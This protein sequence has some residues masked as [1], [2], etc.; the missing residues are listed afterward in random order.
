[1]RSCRIW[2]VLVFPVVVV[3]FIVG[4]PFRVVIGIRVRVRIVI[5][6]RIRVGIGIGIRIRI[7]VF[8]G[9]FL[10]GVDYHLIL[11]WLCLY[12]LLLFLSVLALEF[13]VSYWL[14]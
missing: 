8:F 11:F 5:R 10:F 4:V 14:C 13:D 1:M 6:I 2:S 12:H 9:R 3:H 7:G